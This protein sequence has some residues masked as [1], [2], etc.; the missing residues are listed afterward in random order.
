VGPAGPAGGISAYGYI[1][2]LTPQTV[3]IGGSVTFDSTGP[4]LGVTHAIGSASVNVVAAGDY[5]IDFSVSGTEPN[6]F[7]LFVNGVQAVGS[8]YGSGAGTQQNT[9]FLIVTLSAGDTL[10][11]RNNSSA[12]AVGLASVIGGTQMNVNA[13]LLIEKLS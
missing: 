1:F 7:A 4:L 8:V 10:T 9:G 13:S 3:P 6:Q 12:A 2:N 11:L 5:A